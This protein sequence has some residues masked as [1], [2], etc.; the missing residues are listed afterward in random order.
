[1]PGMVVYACN[2]RRLSKENLEFRASLS[3]TQILYLKQN[4]TEAKF[5][6]VIR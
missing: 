6:P 5:S 3:H 2:L 1:M 4:D